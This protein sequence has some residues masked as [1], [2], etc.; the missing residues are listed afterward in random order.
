MKVFTIESGK[1]TAGAQTTVREISGGTVKL[2]VVEV[3]EEGRGRRYDFLPVQN[4][5][6]AKDIHCAIIGETRSGKPKLVAAQDD[7]NRDEC[8]VVFRTKIGFRGGNSHTGD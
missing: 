1:V 8:L 3:G 4:I 2:N 7:G 5:G 6:E